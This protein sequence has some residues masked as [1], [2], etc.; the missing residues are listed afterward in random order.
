[1]SELRIKLQNYRAFSNDAPL[2]MTVQE[3]ITFFLGVNN[4]G[5][6]ALLRTF[7]ELRLAFTRQQL[8][9]ARSGAPHNFQVTLSST[10]DRLVHRRHTGQPIR[11][12]ITEGGTG[13]WL[14]LKAT[15]P[16][17]HTQTYQALM[18][19][20][21]QPSDELLNDV[22]GLFQRSMY[23][24]PFRS[25]AVQFSER[26]YDIQI[27]R[28][29]VTEWDSWANGAR[30]DRNEEIERL[31]DELKVL[32]GFQKFAITVSQN[33]DMLYVTTDDGRFSLSELGDGLAHYIIVLGN[34]V[35]RK[36]AYIFIDEPEIGLHPRMQEVFVR[37][38]ASKARLGLLATSHSVGLARSVGDR[39][40]T[41]T[42][43]A[44]GRR[45]CVPF[46]QHQA[47]TLVQS[48][49]ELSYSQ[50]AE[51]GGNHV[52]LVE[53]R[54]DI[55]SY[56]EIL[57]KFQLDQHFIIWALNGS[58]WIKAKEANVADELGE[59]KR[60]GAK[61]ISVFFDSER[62]SDG[63]ALTQHLQRFRDLCA[64]LGFNVFPTDRHST[65][66]YIS[67]K[68]LDD[69]APGQRTLG[70]FEPFTGRPSKWDKNKN[71]LMFQKM[72]ANDFD[73]TELKEFIVGKLAKL[74]REGATKP[75]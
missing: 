75:S 36:P 37:A 11:V 61:S 50:Y 6:S 55:K 42:R 73:G 56:R 4:V 18:S 14:E 49:S 65:E 59:L 67:Q 8:S 1:M 24:G 63:A 44:D 34:A 27:G 51:L 7:Y 2:E 3:G 41:I 58:D 46:G 43:E 66:N 70:A 57:R 35:I 9:A 28:G 20:A 12:S 31:I 47:P 68:A 13:W 25:P 69:I 26:L 23:V 30:V 19:V 5:K 53:G 10:F 29:F 15:S 71:W 33:T 60:L 45:R 72:N 39:V 54:T 17:P 74:V 21:G 52:L 22:E 62:T 16:D 40:Y 64:K 32:F 48:I 38:L